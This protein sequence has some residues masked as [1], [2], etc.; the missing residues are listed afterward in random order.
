MVGVDV[1]GAIDGVP[2]IVPVIGSIAEAFVACYGRTV[3]A[4]PGRRLR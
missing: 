2:G 3:E 1:A 4:Y